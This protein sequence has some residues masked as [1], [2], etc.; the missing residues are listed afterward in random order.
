MR[1]P[2]SRAPPGGPQR[3]PPRAPDRRPRRVDRSAASSGRRGAAV[4]PH[5]PLSFRSPACPL[6]SSPTPCPP[7][8]PPRHP[9]R[10]P[11]PSPRPA[12]LRPV[13]L[14]RPLRPTDRVGCGVDPSARPCW[15]A[16]LS[17]ALTVL[18]AGPASAHDAFTGSTPAN[19]STVATT[20]D[21]VTLDFEEPPTTI[22]LTVKVTG[23]SG[24]VQ[25]GAATIEGSKVVQALEP[26]APA[27]SYRIAWRV[28]SDDGHPV[29]GELTFTSTAANARGATATPLTPGGASATTD[30][31]AATPRHHPPPPR[32][33]SQPPRRR[34]PPAAA[35]RPCP[36]SS[37]SSSSSWP[38][39]SPPSS[40]AA[41][42]RPDAT[43]RPG[44]LGHFTL[45]MPCPTRWGTA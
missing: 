18:G 43:P 1:R 28:T 11:C 12:P 17:M 4:R 32:P 5:P 10:R 7:R 8:R 41:A 24:D 20:P 19:G 16:A 25:Q 9:R 45:A 29:S 15:V 14:T 3:C 6:S 38:P 37:S 39:P 34:R 23:P 40:C 2:P 13:L 27:G 30:A 26:G 31:S 33:P 42:A 22:G 21:S 36:S 35:A 44:P